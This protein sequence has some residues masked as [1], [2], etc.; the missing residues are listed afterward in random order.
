[1]DQNILTFRREKISN[2][3]YANLNYRKVRLKIGFTENFKN[4]LVR[5][6][7]TKRFKKK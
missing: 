1:M 4:K 2:Y 3:Q 5:K 7:N 6:L